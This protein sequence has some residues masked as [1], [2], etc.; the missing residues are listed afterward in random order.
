MFNLLNVKWGEPTFGTPS[1]TVTW[2]SE[3]GG[4]LDIVGGSDLND[5]LGS[6]RTAFNAWESVAAVDFQEVVA[7]GNITVS[8]E[9]LASPTVA[10][11]TLFYNRLPGI[12]TFSSV[13]IKF[14]SNET[15]APF[16]G[17]GFGIID[18]YA[19][20]VHEIGHAIGLGHPMPPDPSQIMNFE[21]GVSDLSDI[22]IAGAQAIYGTVGADVEVP[23][24][25]SGGGGGGGGAVGLLLGLLA[26]LSTLFTG[27]AGAAV[28]MAAAR[29]YDETDEDEGTV[30]DVT[31]DDVLVLGAHDCVNVV[32]TYG[33]TAEAYLPMIDFTALPN[34]CGC[35]GLCGH[36]I[37]RGEPFEPVE[38]L[39][40]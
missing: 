11:A 19:I 1:G 37:E 23:L 33:E 27:G 25:E 22:D 39:M 20:A 6:L 4:D 3:L 5:I 2:S 34:P 16:D 8:A 30:G 12:D 9:S 14:S 26:L 32:S 28:A 10:Q 29:V 7:G 18:F 21:V 38:V 35:I 31:S 36:I 17:G 13:D 40:A 15:W 24:A